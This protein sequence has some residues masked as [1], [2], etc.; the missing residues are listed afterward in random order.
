MGVKSGL[1][2]WAFLALLLNLAVNFRVSDSGLRSNGAKSV[3]RVVRCFECNVIVNWCHKFA[4]NFPGFKKSAVIFSS[5]WPRCLS[6]APVFLFASNTLTTPPPS[7][8][9]FVPVT[10]SCSF[11]YITRKTR[12]QPVCSL[13]TDVADNPIIRKDT[14]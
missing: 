9:T 7:P 2:S 11:I 1:G 3:C 5:S 14:A 8:A 13:Q 12:Q 10:M 4:V 6:I